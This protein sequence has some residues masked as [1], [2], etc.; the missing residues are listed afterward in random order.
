MPQDNGESG[1]T[2]IPVMRT[3]VDW[4][5]IA[6]GICI[7]MVVMMHSTLGVERAAGEPGFMGYVVEFA[8]PFRM[9]DFFLIAGLFLARRMDAPW[10]LYLDRK[11]LHFAYFYVL[12][13]TIQF[14][15]K[16]PGL[17][18]E[19]GWQ[20]A[21][22]QYLYAYVDP[23]GTL[24]FIYHLALFFVVTRLVKSIPWPV[25]W[26]VAAALEIAPIHTGS[27]LIDEFAGR[28]VYFYTG[29]IFAARI[30]RFAEEVAR[31]RGTALTGLALWAVLNGL[32]VFNG[33][34]DLPF[35]SLLLGLAGA[36]AI[37]SGATLL[38][39]SVAAESLRWLGA[40]SI[41]VYLA[42]FLPM[43]A[44]RAVLLK[45]GLIPDVGTVSVLVTLAGIAGPV[46]LYWLIQRTG[47]GW[48]LFERPAW[49]RIDRPYRR[50]REAMVPAE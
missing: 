5:D 37:V 2:R 22:G 46:A 6:K 21:L 18:A 43:A 35:V 13:L 17:T 32:V 19:L 30:F 34:A 47:F 45:L 11:V 4:V 16:A 49:A 15:F 28:F 1:K 23:W 38:T 3:R 26:L 44:S 8:R 48:F 27:V 31:D 25:V 41:V 40:H 10:R 42:F 36:L 29:Y 14:A 39:R 33:Y 7:V 9:P 24:W 20:G 50:P 12:W